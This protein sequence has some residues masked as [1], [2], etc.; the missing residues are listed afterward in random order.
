MRTPLI[1]ALTAVFAAT[2]ALT[3]IAEM[4]TIQI[5]DSE[6]LATNAATASSTVSLRSYRPEDNEYS[7]EVVVTGGTITNLLCEVSN[8]G[9]TNRFATPLVSGG[10]RM[11]D[12]ADGF[13]ETSGPGSDGVDVIEF[14][15]PAC[16]FIR[17]KAQ[18]LTTNTTINAV[19]VIR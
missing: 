18:A 3:A 17:F 9:Y 10:T 19:L 8:T 5:W 2:L 6:L 1:A 16:N 7:L 11:A 14:D 12:L 15:P 13:S 4:H